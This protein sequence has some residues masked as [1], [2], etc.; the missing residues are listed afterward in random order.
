MADDVQDGLVEKMAKVSSPE[1][2]K[3]SAGKDIDNQSLVKCEQCVT[4]AKT[5]AL[6]TH[7]CTQNNVFPLKEECQEAATEV[8][9]VCLKALSKFNKMMLTDAAKVHWL[10]HKLCLANLTLPWWLGDVTNQDLNLWRLSCTV[11]NSYFTDPHAGHIFGPLVDQLI[12]N[13]F[14]YPHKQLKNLDNLCQLLCNTYCTVGF[15]DTEFLRNKTHGIMHDKKNELV[16]WNWSTLPVTGK[17]HNKD[18]AYALHIF[19]LTTPFG[20]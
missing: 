12:H 15:I 4:M 19:E 5:H 13:L 10:H 16:G 8:G 11:F 2:G 7:K 14:R 17:V 9:V 18:W 1:V 3:K 6:S 20:N